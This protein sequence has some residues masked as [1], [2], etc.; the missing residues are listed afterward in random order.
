ML[1]AN[2]AVVFADVSPTTT[3]VSKYP[4]L[5]DLAAEPISDVFVVF[6]NR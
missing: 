4:V 2:T 3:L 1:S 6:A 5:N